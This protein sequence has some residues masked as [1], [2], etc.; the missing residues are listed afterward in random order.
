MTSALQVFVVDVDSGERR[1]VTK[2][3]V[4]H[5]FPQWSPDGKTMAVQDPKQQRHVF[6]AWSGHGRDW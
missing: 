6:P 3:A 1:K 2:E 5:Y 4:D